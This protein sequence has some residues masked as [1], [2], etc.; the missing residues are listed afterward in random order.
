MHPCR[1]WLEMFT[2]RLI[3][4]AK[5]VA[6]IALGSNLG[7]SLKTLRQAAKA[8]EKLGNVQER[9]SLYDTT[10]VGGPEGQ[11]NYLNAVITL[12]PFANY[13]QALT[14]LSALLE[15]EQSFGRERR[16]RHDARTLDLDLLIYG[17]L[18]LQDDDLELPHPR[19]MERA[20]VLA[21]LSDIAPKWR[22]PVTKE[23]VQEALER[24]DDAGVR[25][26]SFTWF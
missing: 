26:T 2:W 9:S 6:Y 4:N 23:T 10:P 25:K 18:I 21:P 8:L 1:V 17:N 13:A 12:I 24:L 19:M 7:D 3:V 15:I 14:L 20:F 11:G 5:S 22:H 16:I